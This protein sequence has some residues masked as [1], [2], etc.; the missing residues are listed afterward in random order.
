MLSIYFTLIYNKSQEHHS[1]ICWM[2]AHSC[3]KS[4]YLG[5]PIRLVQR[6]PLLC[7]S[8]FYGSLC[9]LAVTLCVWMQYSAPGVMYS[10]FVPI[11]KLPP[12]SPC[13]YSPLPSFQGHHQ[14]QDKYTFLSKLLVYHI[15]VTGWYEEYILIIQC[16][17]VIY[18]DVMMLSKPLPDSLHW[19]KAR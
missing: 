3:S 17:I 7:R 1:H 8:P 18:T 12:T 6:C 16:L 4:N 11:R 10:L 13:L 2:M 9:I 5:I 14:H 15:D 19:N